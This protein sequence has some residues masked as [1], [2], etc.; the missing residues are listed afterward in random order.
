MATLRIA[1]LTDLHLTASLK[2][3]RW[4]TLERILDFLRNEADPID[5]V[6]LTGDIAKTRFEG[7]YPALREML[8]PWWDK[9][10]LVPGNHDHRDQIQAVFDARLTA[11]GR[12]SAFSEDLAGVRLVG[13]DTARPFRVSGRLGVTQLSWL[14]E[15]LETRLPTIIFMHHPPL[16]VGAW[17]LG[18]DLLRDRKAFAAVLQGKPIRAI[19]CG[20]V[21]QPFEG[22]FHGTPI[23]TTPSTAYQFHP[24][25]LIPRT[26]AAPPGFRI[27]EI[28]ETVITSTRVYHLD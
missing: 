10:R 17:W 3:R 9:L 14:N 26:T 19:V 11:V 27:I 23:L 7:V 13:L 4:H 20:H 24:T 22:T 8:Q 5:R 2:H 15:R 21:H 18:K 12:K 6:I 1:H 28:E 25:S 16:P